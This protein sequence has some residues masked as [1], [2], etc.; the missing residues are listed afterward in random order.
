L[1]HGASLAAA[2]IRRMERSFGAHRC[3]LDP[4]GKFYAAEQQ[5]VDVDGIEPRMADNCGFMAMGLAALSD[6]KL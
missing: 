1:K 2:I 6:R 4:F 5:A 3:G